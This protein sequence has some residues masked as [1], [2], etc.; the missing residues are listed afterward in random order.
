MA[1]SSWEDGG[2]ARKIWVKSYTKKIFL[3]FLKGQD[4]LESLN[5]TDY[6]GREEIVKKERKKFCTKKVRKP[7][8]KNEPKRAGVWY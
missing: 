5:A 1:C 7:N 4:H 3:F 2:P 8:D 6:K